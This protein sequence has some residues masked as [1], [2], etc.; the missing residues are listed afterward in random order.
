MI[1]KTFWSP[2]LNM[3]IEEIDV[4]L[5]IKHPMGVLPITLPCGHPFQLKSLAQIIIS[6]ASINTS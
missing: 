5:T 3:Q 2:K 4:K 6:W 1:Y